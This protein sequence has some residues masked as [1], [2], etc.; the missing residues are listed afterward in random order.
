MRIDKLEA[1]ALTIPFKSAFRHAAAERATTQALWV[2]ASGNG[3][4]GYGEGCPREYVTG[5]T[6]HTAAAFVMQFADEWRGAIRDL[7]TLRSWAAAHAGAIGRNP[8]AWCAVDVSTSGRRL[9]AKQCALGVASSSS[10][11]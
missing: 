1:R 9:R 2:S 7:Q 10:P 4:V 5:E 11:S 3:F 6:L 8:A